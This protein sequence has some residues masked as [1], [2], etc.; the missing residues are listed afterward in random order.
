MFTKVLVNNKTH[1]HTSGG[2]KNTKISIQMFADALK[3]EGEKSVTSSLEGS[4]L[5]FLL[6]IIHITFQQGSLIIEAE[7]DLL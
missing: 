5:L 3:V 1:F 2:W 4:L 6:F 7:G